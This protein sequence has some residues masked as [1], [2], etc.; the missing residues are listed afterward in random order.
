MRFLLKF[1]EYPLKMV[2]RFTFGAW[3]M[4]MALRVDFIG[5]HS[6]NC[7]IHRALS[8]TS[9]SCNMDS[10]YFSVLTGS[11]TTGIH[12]WNLFS[13]CPHNSA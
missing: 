1:Y 8:R 12:A 5:I 11:V 7:S 10:I 4:S 9:D 6:G 3:L 2:Q 13:N